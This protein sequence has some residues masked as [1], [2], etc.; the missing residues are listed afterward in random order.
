MAFT[1]NTIV[2]I[3]LGQVP[4]CIS[5]INAWKYV[6]G[7]YALVFLLPYD[8][9]DMYL[10][11]PAVQTTVSIGVAIHKFL[12][13]VAIVGHTIAGPAYF[14]ALL[15]T[16]DLAASGV[17]LKI[18]RSYMDPY[19]SGDVVTKEFW[20]NAYPGLLCFTPLVYAT[21]DPGYMVAVM[22]LLLR[23]SYESALSLFGLFFV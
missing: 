7:A 4:S 17:V 15:C 19:A 8:L 14:T 3:L 6:F 13:Q 23:F 16:I 20:R 5:D 22:Y 10:Q 9:L 21:G 1:G 2:R 18:A 12:D 11:N